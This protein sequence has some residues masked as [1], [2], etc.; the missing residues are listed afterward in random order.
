MAF[1]KKVTFI[2]GLPGS[3]KSYY[4]KAHMKDFE[5]ALIL[6]DPSVTLV[7]T[8]QALLPIFDQIV[9]VDPILCMKTRREIAERIFE[10][11][12]K[13]WIFFENDFKACWDNV[14]FRNDKR[15]VSQL[16]I[17]TLSAMYDTP[18]G[19]STLPIYRA[20]EETKSSSDSEY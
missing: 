13:T 17:S 19:V 20:K 1:S 15:L 12:K 6:D 10:G 16:Y 3:G 7:G 8:L 9:I 11:W 18:E 5:G 4:L 14:Q 2:V